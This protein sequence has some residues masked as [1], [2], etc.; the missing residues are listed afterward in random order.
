MIFCQLSLG[1][2]PTQISD[3]FTLRQHFDAPS[4]GAAQPYHSQHNL[5]LRRH[6]QHDSTALSPAWL[7][8]T[9]ASMTQHLYRTMAK[10]SRQRHSQH[11]STAPSSAWLSIDITQ[12][13]N[14]RHQ[15][16]QM[17]LAA[18]RHAAS[19]CRYYSPIY[20]VSRPMQAS[21]CASWHHHDASTF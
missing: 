19:S 12:W 15:Q 20:L 4:S 7:G 11:N 14:H 3:F 2:E 8:S 16:W 13:L 9:V 18:S 21:H 10:S 1:Y 5:E 17:F 6:H